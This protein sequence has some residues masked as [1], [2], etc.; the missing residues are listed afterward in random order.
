MD[1]WSRRIVGWEYG[2][3]MDEDLVLG[4]LRRAIKERQPTLGLIHHTDRGG[5]FAGKR[6]REVLRRAGMR[7]SMR[8]G[9]ELLRQCVHGVVLRDGQDGT[10]AGGVRRGCGGGPGDWSTFGTTTWSVVIRRWDTSARSS[11][12]VNW[13]SRNK[14]MD[15]PRT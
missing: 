13:L 1:L 14:R 2:S 5:Q 8:R 10:G 7:Q 4:S 6:Y 12:R 15:C 3:S 11:S 9:G